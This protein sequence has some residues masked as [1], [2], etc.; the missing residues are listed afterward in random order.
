[1]FIMRNLSANL[2]ILQDYVENTPNLSES[3][4]AR[5]EEDI[6]EYRNLRR[7]LGTKKFMKA[8]SFLNY[9]YSKLDAL[10]N[11]Y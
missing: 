6:D 11:P 7:E 5:W 10:D 3:E 2:A 9:D 1:M 8:D 4:I